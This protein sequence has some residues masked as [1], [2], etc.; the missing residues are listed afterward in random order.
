MLTLPIESEIEKEH[1]VIRD[2]NKRQTACAVVIGAS[3][4]IMYSY[5]GSVELGIALAS[6]VI[7]LAGAFGWYKK[8]TLNAEEVVLKRV[9]EYIYHNKTRKYR[10]K[11]LYFSLLNKGYAKLRN[12]DMSD[13]K[14]AELI[15]KAK[16]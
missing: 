4:I 3:V 7:A 6:P 13:K 5:A 8:G 11:N 15:A 14:T 2:F 16:K 1:K 9:K 10:T 12:A